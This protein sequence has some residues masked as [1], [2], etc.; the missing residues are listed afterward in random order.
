VILLFSEQEEL[1]GMV[2]SWQDGQSSSKV[3]RLIM[4]YNKEISINLKLYLVYRN[5]PPSS[6]VIQILRSNKYEVIPII[7]SRLEKALIH[8]NDEGIINEIKELEDPFITRI[9]PYYQ[10]TP[11]LDSTLFYGRDD[12]MERIPQMLTQGQ[13]IGLFGL[14]KVGK[15]SLIQQ[16]QQ[17]LITT[18]SVFIDCQAFEPSAEIYFEEIMSQLQ[19]KFHSLPKSLRSSV[20]FRK[21]FLYLF[22][23]WRKQNQKEPFLIILDEIDKFF[24][25]KNIQSSDKILVEYVKFYR[26][27]RGLAQSHQCLVTFV[28]SFRPVVN[29]INLISPQ[30]GENSMFKSFK[31]QYLGFLETSES[32]RMIKGIG[33]W[34]DIV[35]DNDAA[36][37]VYHYCGGHPLITRYFASLACD[38]GARKHVDYE[39]VEKTAEQIKDTFHLNDIGD[40]YEQSIWALLDKND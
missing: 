20:N 21:Q 12:L 19:E 18:P 28:V 32:V 9:D 10:T 22:E 15:T 27:L 1:K 33:L 17:R 29:R 5:F 23:I 30:I 24:P 14:R 25:D 8:L 38:E 34:K 2:I 40:Y 11:V 7:F 36:E 6:E 13:H 3:I 35:W 16:I 26:I 37:R 4:K 39:K 31:E